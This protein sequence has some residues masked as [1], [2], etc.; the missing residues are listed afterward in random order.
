LVPL[1]VWVATMSGAAALWFDVRSGGALGFVPE[2]A[3]AVA[4]QR[5]GRVATLEVEVGQR[6]RAGHVIATLDAREIDAELEILAAERR[7]IEA[8]LGA[9]RSETE[10]RQSETV[11][12]LEESVESAELALK[13]ARA[14]RDSKSAA[15]KALSTRLQSLR[16]LVE[17]RMADRRQLDEVTVEHS[18]LQ[19]EVVTAD[20]M[21]AQLV[22]QVASA[23]AR[24][25]M[26]PGDAAVAATEP[27]RAE[28]S[29]LERR[30]QLL[31]LRRGETILRAPTDGQVAAIRARPGEVVEA[32]APVVTMVGDAPNPARVLVCLGEQEAG[33][34]RLGEA[35]RLYP[36]GTQGV[37]LA[38]HVVAL[39]PGVAELPIRCRRD[40]QVPVWGREVAVALDEP[41]TVLPGQAFAVAFTG[42]VDDRSG[43]SARTVELDAA[44]APAAPAPVVKG[45]PAPAG[46][47]AIAVPPELAARTRIE[48]S[49][50]LWVDRL[51]KFVIVSDDTGHQDRGEKAPWLLT[52]DA[53][54]RLDPA[55]L[56][57]EG[58]KSVDDL[59]S[60]APGPEGSLYV[61]S[62]QSHN[63][64][65]KRGKPRQVFARV[66]LEGERARVDGS[67]HLAALLDAAAPAVR[68][69]LGLTDTAALDLEGMTAT[70]TGGLLIGLKA[71]LTSEGA[72]I[73]WHMQR[74]ERL[75]AGEGLAAAGL[76][77]WGEV[78][79]T[80]EADGAAAHG[81]ISELLELTDGSLLVAATASGADPA[82]QSGSLWHVAGKPG[83]AAPRLVREFEGLKPEGLSYDSSG[84]IA[85]VFDTGDTAP[86][87]TEL[88]W[89]PAP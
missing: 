19:G 88:P 36:R 21:I 89:P 32:G 56:V 71:P 50:L 8:Q 70:A 84:K 51:G 16:E 41:M 48:P 30:V 46:P 60:I 11:R 53:R 66:V 31:E 29:I 2:A 64:N 58:L 12:G 17:Q 75:L 40:P 79:L 20:A 7:R 14:A 4:P 10:I 86:L 54:G 34:V 42:E 39:G 67:V 9:V 37:A 81:G 38:G 85:V 74:P 43:M 5:A 27:M 22:G 73:V 49:G 26:M 65:G 6:V 57:I 68:A 80:V 23:R 33:K 15:L 47:T 45:P 3:L 82:Q 28:L 13:A 52:M 78:R 61:L 18:A 24:R 63:K 87:W 55:P 25:G 69:E 62:S 72:A 35:A 77:R 76:V 83:S 44:P 59:E 1:V